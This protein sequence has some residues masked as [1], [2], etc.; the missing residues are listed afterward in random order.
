MQGQHSGSGEVLNGCDRIE[1]I[2]VEYFRFS[3]DNLASVSEITVGYK[4]VKFPWKLR[5]F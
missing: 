3:I 5:L 2:I 1:E 4:L